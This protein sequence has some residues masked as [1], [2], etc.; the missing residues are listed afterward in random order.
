MQQKYLLTKRV[1]AMARHGKK[2]RNWASV[3]RKGK[4]EGCISGS[5]HVGRGS[6]K[7]IAVDATVRLR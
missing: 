6:L 4:K 7:E 2:L 1:L 3:G 5:G